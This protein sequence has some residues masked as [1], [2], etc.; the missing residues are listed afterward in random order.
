MCHQ[1]LRPR[2]DHLWGGEPHES[3]DTSSSVLVTIT[4]SARPE[5]REDNQK[6][7]RSV[8]LQMSDFGIPYRGPL[9]PTTNLPTKGTTSFSRRKNGDSNIAMSHSKQKLVKKFG[10][11]RQGRCELGKNPRSLSPAR[12]RWSRWALPEEPRGCGKR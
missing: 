11:G 4:P 12:A 1:K 2:D 6:M 7:A 9:L 10:P 8:R 5:M 3:S